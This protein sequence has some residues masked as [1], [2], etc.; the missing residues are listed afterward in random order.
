MYVINISV[1]DGQKLT[2]RKKNLNCWFLRGSIIY[3]DVVFKDHYLQIKPYFLFLHLYLNGY[4]NF[5]YGV[6]LIITVEI[7]LG[8]VVISLINK[9]HIAPPALAAHTVS[10]PSCHR[11]APW[12]RHRST[13]SRQG[14]MWRHGP[15]LKRTGAT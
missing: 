8:V 12:H 11:C 3:F 2:R 14:W 5:Y 15:A 4:Y 7:P 10:A 6:L 1:F 13:C 9:P